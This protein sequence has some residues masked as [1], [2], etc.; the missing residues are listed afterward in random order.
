MPPSKALS[1][2]V[3]SGDAVFALPPMI[4]GKIRW[5]R[6]LGVPVGD[7]CSGFRI[8]SQ[9]HTVTQFRMTD[10][11][12]APIPGTGIWKPPVSVPCSSAPDEGD[13][14]VLTFVVPDVHLNA[15]PDGRYRMIVELTGN[16]DESRLKMMLMPGFRRIEP[17]S[18]YVQLV[19]ERHIASLDFE[20]VFQRQHFLSIG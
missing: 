10:H 16:W 11:G 17:I 20:V 5:N 1:S 18:Y 13:Q 19:K 14:H 7:P 12:P 3:L 9:E 6:D 2:E 8:Q 15:F 4:F